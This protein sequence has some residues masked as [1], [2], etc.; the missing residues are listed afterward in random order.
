MFFVEKKGENYKKDWDRFDLT[1]NCTVVPEG[2]IND[3]PPE[4]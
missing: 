1:P 3:Y 4:S 2:W